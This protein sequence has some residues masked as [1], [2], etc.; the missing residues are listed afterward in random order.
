MSRI[1][2]KYT[3]S[4]KNKTAASVA[5]F[6][7]L[8]FAVSLVALPAANAHAPPWQIIS[9]AYVSAVPQTVGVGQSV[10]IVMW[11]SILMPNAALTND[12]R[13]QNYRLNITK[14]GG[15]T[16]TLGPFTADPTSTIYTNYKPDQVGNYSVVFWY[17][18]LVYRWNDTSAMRTWTNDT[19]LGATS[20]ILT[21]SVLE[22]PVPEAIKSY[23]LPTEY[24]TWPIEGQNT[25]WYK[26][27]S[28]WLGQGSP[29]IK[30]NTWNVQS[31]GVGPNSAHVMWSKP[32]QDGGVVG[33][34]HV[35]LEGNT[36]YQGGSYNHRY[37]NPI[38]MHGRIF[39]R[40]PFGLSG[41]AGDTVAVDLRTGE[42][43]WRRDDLPTLSFGYYYD[44]DT[45]NQHGVFYEGMLF[46]SNFGRAFDPRTGDP[47]FNVTNVPS[48][49][50]VSQTEGGAQ[51]LGPKGEILRFVI[52]N[53]GSTAN[54]DWRLLQWNSSKL[55]NLDAL[56]PSIPSE[57][58]ASTPNRYDWNVSINSWRRGMSSFVVVASAIDDVL[59]GYNGTLPYWDNQVTEY[60]MWAISLKP[61]TRGQQLWMKTYT[62]PKGVSIQMRPADTDTRVFVV[63]H[64]ELLSYYGYNLD[65]GEPLW[66]PVTMQEPFAFFAGAPATNPSRVGSSVIAYGNLYLSGY[67]GVLYAVDLKTGKPQWTYG[68]GGPGNSTFTALGT[69][70]GNMPIFI[71]AIADGKVYL[72]T[73]EHSPN[74]PQYKGAL[75]RALNATTGKE[76][77]TLSGWGEGESFMGGN[78]AIADGYYTYINTYD[79]QI[80]TVG[81]GPSATTVSIKNDVITQG[82]SILIQG[83]VTD[84]S[85]GS[86]QKEQAARFPNGVP[87]VSDESMKAWMEY[88]YMQKP[89]PTN[90]TG[91]EV[92]LSVLD[93]NGN[94]RE[95]GKTTTD[96]DGFFS[97]MWQPDIAGKYTV[98]ASFVGSE[99][100]WPSHAET[101]FGVVSA[102]P[103][104]PEPE[105]APPDMTGTYV[106][107]AA[108]AIIIA[109]AI[110]GAIIILA[111]RKRL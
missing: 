68:N 97:S 11:S 21:I 72:F 44:A 62:A 60:T 69:P 110:V 76:M 94:F 74:T 91:V 73:N 29:Q 7:I 6:F 18:D 66:G 37:S 43:I 55:W 2:V 10:F 41:A 39:Y 15:E 89:R 81:K 96:S 82:N 13:M 26:V 46:T 48:M 45:P 31:D 38:I 1:S 106:T 40:E 17:P 59:L 64:R 111:L 30:R 105:P 102:P 80:Y 52:Q 23:P 99:S 93:S 53:A 36:F 19:F 22:D 71:G 34:T 61:E 25:D 9:Y 16:V 24:W 103:A 86:K 54:P 35:G 108:I 77:W 63:Y 70:W 27:S 98:Y 92:I 32:I 28:H 85:A 33:G 47:L 20:K 8:T 84:I 12:I 95:I 67:G 3:K 49:P 88:V 83:T 78:G 79:M 75:I 107:Y 5:V 109:I 65:N 14:P 90:A 57:V 56:T 104:S 42:E 58:N 87:A 100:Y 4:L 50:T 101:A 51:A